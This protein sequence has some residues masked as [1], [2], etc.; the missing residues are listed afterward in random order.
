MSRSEWVKVSSNICN[1][2][3]L[4]EKGDDDDEKNVT[5]MFAFRNEKRFY[6]FKA[7]IIFMVVSKIQ[8]K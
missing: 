4:I 1:Q 3:C 5:V 8:N 6:M 2:F 7:I